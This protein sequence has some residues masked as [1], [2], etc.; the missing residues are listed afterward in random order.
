MKKQMRD[1]ILSMVGSCVNGMRLT[2]YDLIRKP[3]IY[4]LSFQFTHVKPVKLRPTHAKIM[5]CWNGTEWSL[6]RL[7]SSLHSRR[8]GDI[9]CG[10]LGEVRGDRSWHERKEGYTLSLSARAS[11]AFS[12]SPCAGFSLLPRFPTPRALYYSSARYAGYLFSVDI[13]IQS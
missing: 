10:V 3:F 12:R 4:R 1:G 9:R 5:R 11:S 7:F 2:L 6:V 13:C 8:L